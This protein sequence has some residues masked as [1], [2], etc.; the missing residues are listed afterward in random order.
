MNDT[1][2]PKIVVIGGGTGL[3]ILLRG[4]KQHTSNITA[5]VAVSD[6]GG[7]SGVLREDLGMLPPGDI[8]NCIL[9]LANREPIMTELL[10]YR[11]TEGRLKGQNFGNL[12]IAAMVGISSSFEEGVHRI[13]EIL[14][15]TGKVIPV[16]NECI[17]L[18][19]KLENG[20]IVVGESN[21]PYEALKCKSKIDCI[22]IRPKNAKP[23]D[24][25]IK[26]ICS[27]DII[28]L[29]PGSL[30]T[31]IIPNILVKDVDR[32]LNEAKGPKVFICN[33]MTQP[34][35]TDDF[36]VKEHLEAFFKHSDYRYIDYVVV[37]NGMLGD[38]VLVKYTI[39]GAQQITM[40]KDDEKYIEDHGIKLITDDFTEIK[41]GYLRHDAFKVSKVIIDSLKIT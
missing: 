29:G 1:F 23:I 25:V 21:I 17:D 32:A 19:A 38:D 33:L 20:R 35:E 13:N 14:A 26:E 41:M 11:F 36:G 34:G 22:S 10:Q 15:V 39:E 18:V 30:Y 6:D 28:F 40:T 2:G 24:S 12:L 31:S 7:G 4:L 27:A 5:V 9:S 37:N 8:R 3:S 16:S